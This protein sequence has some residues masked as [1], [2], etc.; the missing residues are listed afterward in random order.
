MLDM[1]TKMS[2]LYYRVTGALN[3]TYRPLD[4]IP[5][6]RF[7]YPPEQ[8]QTAL[9]EFDAFVRSLRAVGYEAGIVSFLDVL[10][11]ALME[12]ANVSAADLPGCL[13]QYEIADRQD[14]L[15]R[16]HTYLPSHLIFELKNRLR[17]YSPSA[18]I[19]LTRTGVLFPLVRLSSLLASLEGQTNQPLVVLYPG[20]REGAMLRDSSFDMATTHYYRGEVL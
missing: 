4:G 5:F 3:K 11:A 1:Q 7:L 16:L 12:M 20:D 2:E 10:E 6:F 19:V 13:K 14:F 15:F 17:E 18:C 8:E 9:R